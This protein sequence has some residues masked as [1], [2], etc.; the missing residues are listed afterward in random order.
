MYSKFSEH[1]CFEGHNK[2]M[3]NTIF[4]AARI[5]VCLQTLDEWG[6]W[7]PRGC[8]E[9]STLS[10]PAL[11]MELD[12]HLFK[13]LTGHKVI[14]SGAKSIPSK[15]ISLILEEP[16]HSWSPG[17]GL[18][19]SANVYQVF[20]LGWRAAVPN[21][22]FRSTWHGSSTFSIFCTGGTIIKDWSVEKIISLVSWTVSKHGGSP[23]H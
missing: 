9:M 18:V 11:L 22:Q 14:L 6:V 21:S 23:A 7:V 16:C 19:S 4:P 8:P 17:R 20:P 13:G 5:S 10:F 12:K 2:A 15:V 1:S 3:S